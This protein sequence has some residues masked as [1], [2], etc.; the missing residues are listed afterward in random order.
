MGSEIDPVRA[1]HT[2]I[3]LVGSEYC[4]LSLASIAESQAVKRV[5]E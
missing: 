5:H 1:K 2:W 4:Q 3:S